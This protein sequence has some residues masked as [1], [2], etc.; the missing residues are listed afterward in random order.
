MG[1]PGQ[2]KLQPYFPKQPGS[3]VFAYLWA[4]T[5]SC[6]GYGQAGATQPQLVVAHR[7]RS[8]G[9]GLEL[10]SDRNVCRFE[11]VYGTIAWHSQLPMKV[12]Q[13][14]R[15]T[16]A[17]D[18][19]DDIEG[20]HQGRGPSGQNDRNAICYCPQDESLAS[21]LLVPEV[22]MISQRYRQRKRRAGQLE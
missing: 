4:R 14:R 7:R 22:M 18:R 6:P 3:S 17:M 20:A 12:H 16:V 1:E 2:R 21:S 15:G 5:I 19:R 10:Q 13:R 8:G 11:I 9:R